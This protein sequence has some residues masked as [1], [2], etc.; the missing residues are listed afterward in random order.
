MTRGSLAERAMGGEQPLALN[1]GVDGEPEPGHGPGD[2]LDRPVV[3][4]LI[5]DTDLGGQLGAVG[6][7]PTDSATSPTFSNQRYLVED[8]DQHLDEHL[9]P[10]WGEM[11]RDLLGG[12]FVALG[13][14][15]RPR[16]ALTGWTTMADLQVAI[17]GETVEMVT[18]DIRVDAEQLGYGGSGEWLGR[19]P[20]RDVDGPTSGITQAAVRSEILDSRVLVSM[21]GTN[22]PKL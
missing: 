5:G 14:A 6:T 20:D 8:P 12:R 7:H 18:G 10:A 1:V 22:R 17:I 21:R 11:D 2:R 9:E 4:G 16:A 13:R 3:A 19:F 15:T